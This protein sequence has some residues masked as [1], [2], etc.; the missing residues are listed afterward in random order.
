MAV[1]RFCLTESMMI[2]KGHS[3]STQICVTGCRRSI[4]CKAKR[5]K[6]SLILFLKTTAIFDLV[7]EGIVLVVIVYTICTVLLL[8]C[9]VSKL[10]P[11]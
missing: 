3:L 7:S 5:N 11:S 4:F 6:I 2:P 8:D 10:L 9:T 1:D